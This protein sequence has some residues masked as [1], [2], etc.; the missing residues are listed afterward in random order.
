MFEK[1]PE[2]APLEKSIILFYF[3]LAFDVV[4]VLLQSKKSA[5]SQ[6]IAASLNERLVSMQCT[7]S[8]LSSCLGLMWSLACI[9]IEVSFVFVEERIIHLIRGTQVQTDVQN[10]I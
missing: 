6:Q 10:N 5:F 1:R 4:S 7:K 9:E 3:L 2:F 8:A